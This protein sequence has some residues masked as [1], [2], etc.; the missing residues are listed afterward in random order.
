MRPLTLAPLARGWALFCAAIVMSCAPALHPAPQRPAPS[1][2]VA[3]TS[4]LLPVRSED[5]SIAALLDTMSVQS[6]TLARLM[7]E[8]SEHQGIVYVVPGRCP[9]RGLKGC[10]L[11]LVHD[12]DD[13]RYLW[14]RVAPSDDRVALVSTIAHELQHA[15]EVLQQPSIRTSREVVEFYRS[16]PSHAF[17]GV[18]GPFRSYETAAAIEVAGA[19]RAELTAYAAAAL[20]DD[21]ER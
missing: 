10:L 17:A 12:A 3:P 13:V 5:S 16:W 8:I 19:V 11:H 9:V 2:M 14:I 18:W 4:G 15:V 1:S 20:E 6:A 7:R 21:R